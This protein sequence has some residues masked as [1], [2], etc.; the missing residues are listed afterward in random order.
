MSSIPPVGDGEVPRV[1]FMLPTHSK[2]P[3]LP[4]SSRAS[5]QGRQ[6]PHSVSA[7]GSPSRTPAASLPPLPVMSTHTSSKVPQL[8]VSSRASS[9]GRHSP[10]PVSASG[11]PSRTS[12][13]SPPPRPVMSTHTSSKIPKAPQSPSKAPLLKSHKSTPGHVGMRAAR[14]SLPKTLVRGRPQTPTINSPTPLRPISCP[15]ANYDKP[16]PSPPI[17][18]VVDPNSPPKAQRTLVDAEAGSPSEEQWP[19]LRPEPVSRGPEDLTTNVTVDQQPQPC[20]VVVTEQSISR[21]NTNTLKD[22]NILPSTAL[23]V[24]QPTVIQTRDE[25]VPIHDARVLGANGPRRFSSR[26]PYGNGHHAVSS[27]DNAAVHIPVDRNET[28]AMS[29]L[30]PPRSSSHRISQPMF[31]RPQPELPIRPVSAS[32]GKSKMRSVDWPLSSPQSEKTAHVGSSK[33]SSEEQTV[34][35]IQSVAQVP[36]QQATGASLE[37]EAEMS[38]RQSELSTPQ[39][40]SCSPNHSLAT[41]SPEGLSEDPESEAGISIFQALVLPASVQTGVGHS[42]SSMSLPREALVSQHPWLYN[43]ESTYWSRTLSWQDEKPFQGPT[44]RIHRDADAFLLDNGVAPPEEP[45]EP[46]QPPGRVSL[47]RSIGAL[48]KRISKQTMSSSPSTAE[49]PT[50]TPSRISTSVNTTSPVVTSPI[51]PIR[52]MKPARQPSATYTPRR[53]LSGSRRWSQSRRTSKERAQLAVAGSPVTETTKGRISVSPVEVVE[54][55]EVCITV[56]MSRRSTYS[57]QELEEEYTPEPV[58]ST[59]GKKARRVLG[60]GREVPN[61]MKPTLSSARARKEYKLGSTSGQARLSNRE[62]PGADPSTSVGESSPSLRPAASR[63]GPSKLRTSTIATPASD[64]SRVESVSCAT[65]TPSGWAR[66]CSPAALDS[67]ATTQPPVE[68]EGV[69]K[70]SSN[71]RL[72]AKRSFRN[73]FPKNDT[74]AASTS[75]LPQSISK[76]TEQRRASIANSGK[77]LAKRLS[78]NFSRTYLPSKAPEAPE[79]EMQNLKAL[80]KRDASLAGFEAAAPTKAPD[81]PEIELQNL[82]ALIKRQSSVAVV[83]VVTP[84][85]TSDVHEVE[86]QKLEALIKRNATVVTSEAASPAAAPEP[87]TTPCPALVAAPPIAA[88]APAPVP[89]IDMAMLIRDLISGVTGTN[90]P[91]PD[92][93]HLLRLAE[94][95]MNIS[96]HSCKS[97]TSA[98]KV[99]KHTRD[100]ELLRHRTAIDLERLGQ[101]L[102]HEVEDEE[103][104]ELVEDVKAMKKRLEDAIGFE[105]GEKE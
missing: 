15:L 5:S 29:L 63:A 98:E 91:S 6:S 90:N 59:P 8:P 71:L 50:H 16:L 39:R 54:T 97:Q 86:L 25:N 64:S 36:E 80:V 96:E 41:R 42:Q 84:T 89:N 93:V 7:S 56:E 17:A 78:K 48:T 14:S 47:S 13:A 26:N 95:L 104:K 103:D 74:K 82:N 75:R 60:I 66:S 35:V 49:L 19:I 99:R 31:G 85:K 2:I 53:T 12:A 70:K 55:E 77:T 40:H 102:D 3:Q 67:Y 52:S 20:H 28:R 76:P 44:L 81:V 43:P 61:W 79:F 23:D 45:E 11:S 27:T 88:P 87:P 69:S 94:V 4:V 62:F 100:V 34:S 101:L 92:N 33:S 9:Q 83:E 72:K 65:Q 68:A 51:S 18:Q 46:K 37:L 58:R 32:M 105:V 38:D 22:T 57:G 10:H 30:I 21:V 73:L 1:K 24:S